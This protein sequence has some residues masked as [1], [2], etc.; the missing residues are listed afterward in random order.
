MKIIAFYLPQFHEIPENNEWWGQG[1]TEWTNTRK[2]KSLF[3]GQDQPKEPLGDNYYDLLD[4]KI[5]LWQINLAKEYEIYGFCYYHYWFNGKK[6]LEKPMEQM[7]QNKELD[8]PFCISWANEPWTR[9][10]DGKTRDT[11]IGQN[12]GEKD[13]WENHFN[14]LLS[15]FKDERYIKVNNMPMV[16]LY[17]LESIPNNQEMII[18]WNKLAQKNGFDGIHLVETL[19]GLQKKPCSEYSNAVI[20][21]EPNYTIHHDR[22]FIDKITNKLLNIISMPFKGK[23]IYKAFNYDITWRRIIKRKMKF[24]NKK[25]YTGAFVDWDNTARKGE[26]A[27]FFIGATPKKFYK[28]LKLQIYKTKKIH[29]SEFLFINAWN[30]WA[31]GTYLE[32]DKK[33]NYE[34]LQ[35]VKKAVQNDINKVD[36]KKS[37]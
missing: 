5:K 12:Y 24:N 26:K 27:T 10:W 15:F 31:E 8:L 19:N 36:I 20:Q 2:A 23:N 28:Y 25:I 21:F 11:L 33:H 9:A 16:V 34:Y 13:D 18:F 37:K 14:Y 17:K 35:M 29:N 1:F 22:K 3:K 6:L 30:E 32:P 4:D 7:L